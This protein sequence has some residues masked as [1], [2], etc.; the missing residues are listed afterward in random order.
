MPRGKSCTVSN[1]HVAKT[2]HFSILVRPGNFFKQIFFFRDV[3]KFFFF[4]QDENHNMPKLQGQNAY[5]SLKSIT[6]YVREGK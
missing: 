2:Y 3:F 4:L 1:Y 5:L 6:H